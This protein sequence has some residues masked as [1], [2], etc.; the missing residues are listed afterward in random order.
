VSE[1][2]IRR[3]GLNDTDN[4]VKWRNQSFVRNK[5][6]FQGE[7]TKSNHIE[8]YKNN[9]ETGRVIQF[10][11]SIKGDGELQFTDVGTAFLKNIDSNNKKAEFGIFIG[12]PSALGQGYG[13]AAIKKIMCY[14]FEELKLNRIY[15]QVLDNNLP[16]IK[17]YQKSGFM[18]EGVLKQSFF[19]DDA[20]IDVCVMAITKDNWEKLVN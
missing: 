3:I 14:A 19:V 7:L 12:E 6:F 15:L 11:I 1:V 16:A 10:I 13:T 9:I 2:A 5:L 4:I 20:F 17:S 18:I 8:Y